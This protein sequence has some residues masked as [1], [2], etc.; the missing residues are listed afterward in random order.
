MRTEVVARHFEIRARETLAALPQEYVRPEEAPKPG[1]AVRQYR[2]LGPGQFFLSPTTEEQRQ[3]V[4]E[5]QRLRDKGAKEG[6]ITDY[7]SPEVVEWECRAKRI[8]GI[9]IFSRWAVVGT[10]PIQIEA[11]VQTTAA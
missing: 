6:M 4:A 5:L 8:F 11:P 3:A 1:E 9:Q 2:R 10:T 7:G